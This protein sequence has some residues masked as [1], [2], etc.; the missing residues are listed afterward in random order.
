MAVAKSGTKTVKCPVCKGKGR[1][2]VRAT[3][4]TVQGERE[5][6]PVE[7]DCIWC[8]GKGA[9]TPEEYREYLEVTDMWC[10][11]EEP[12]E[13]IFHP[14]GESDFCRK[15]HWTCSKCGKITQVG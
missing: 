2:T 15:H 10:E 11:C 5:L 8:H 9:L 7:I 6:D 12:G 14:D 13:A 1:Q 4:V 3:E